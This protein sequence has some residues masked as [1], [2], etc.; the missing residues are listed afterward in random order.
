MDSAAAPISTVSDATS[1]SPR[2]LWRGDGLA[3]HDPPGIATGFAALDAVLPGHGW[4]PGALTELFTPPATEA[5]G[6]LRLLTPTWARLEAAGHS[7][8]WISSPQLSRLPVLPHAPALAQAGLDL[9][10]MVVVRPVS[11]AEALWA[12][13]Q[14]LR[15]INAGAVVAWFERATPAHLRRL[16]LAG[17]GRSMFTAVFR[18][19]A[20]ASQASP[21]PLRIG[22]K[23][24]AQ[25]LWLDV[26]K[27]RGP[28]LSQP[29]LIEL[30]SLQRAHES[31]RSNEP[32]AF[33]E[34]ADFAEPTDSAK[35]MPPRSPPTNGLEGITEGAA[36]VK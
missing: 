12:C 8:F 7:L 18:P 33:V 27:R 23:P 14:I 25:G 34:P 30:P 5:I 32:A 36:D 2:H 19:F 4:P 31:A 10:R 3:Q 26:V 28:P 1:I 35:S 15:T 21:A 16:Q 17:E 9:A 11:E 6:E 20:C 29:L 22:L 24:H 13:E